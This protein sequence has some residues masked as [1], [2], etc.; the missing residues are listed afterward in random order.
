VSLV[1]VDRPS[2]G[3]ALLTLNRPE[4]YNALSTDLLRALVEA[5]DRL[6]D[7][8]SLRALVLTGAGAAF[9]A[10]LDLHELETGPSAF[11]DYS[12]A[13]L[14]SFPVPT[15]AAV[16]G[17]AVT[18]GL[19]LALACDFRV[20]SDRARFA[21]TH[22]RVGVVPAWG[23]TW[24]LPAAVGQSWARQMSFTGNFVDAALA[25]RIGLVNDVLPHDELI[26]GALRLAD[27]I[28]GTNVETLNRI[29]EIY[30]AV[31]TGSAADAIHAELESASDG[32]T[33]AAPGEF[34]AR[35]ASVFSRGKQQ[36]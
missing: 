3:V 16:N 23:L 9:C 18:G 19:E 35:R 25:A 32:L 24:R 8:T 1:L 29:R 36:N 31:A 4:K 11:D 17:V 30:D 33:I 26:A 7:D 6:A 21:D 34:A 10:G 12:L 15:I 22:A 20:A 27:D 5:L 28:T 2:D 13:G 14:Q